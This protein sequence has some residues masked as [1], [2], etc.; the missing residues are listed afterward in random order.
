MRAPKAVRQLASIKAPETV[1]LLLDLVRTDAT[2][3]VR[4][5]A[6]RALAGFD[7]PKLGAD[8]LATWKDY[9][10][11]LRPEVVNTLVDAQGVGEIVASS[12]GRQED[13][14]R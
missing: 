1:P 10:K 14:P 13:R 7:V 9:P 3:A 12:D 8:L 4:S 5:E 2:D 11:S 6:A